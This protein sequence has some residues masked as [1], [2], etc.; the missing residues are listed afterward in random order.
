M[1]MHKKDPV[2]KNNILFTAFF[3]KLTSFRALLLHI[4]EP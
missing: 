1:A 4:G 2:T 3:I